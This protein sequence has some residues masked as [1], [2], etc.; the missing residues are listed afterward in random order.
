MKTIKIGFVGYS[1]SQFDNDTANK[2]LDN[3]F[4]EINEKYPKQEYNVEIVAGGTALGIPLLVYRHSIINEYKNIGFMC[5]QGY[6]YSLYPCDI[7]YA[8][9]EHW[10]DES[11][12]FID[13]IDVLYKI[14]GGMQSMNEVQLAKNK[15]KIVYEFDLSKIEG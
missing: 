14:G 11:E 3:I 6:N 7:I 8:I 4:K 5:K 15:N 13:Y 9:G 12:S 10:G 2:I 1:I